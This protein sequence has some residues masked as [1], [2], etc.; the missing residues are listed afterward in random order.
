MNCEKTLKAHVA[1]CNIKDNTNF[2]SFTKL[3]QD[4]S[5]ANYPTAEGNCMVIGSTK[6]AIHPYS[7]ISN[8]TKDAIPSDKNVSGRTEE[9]IPQFERGSGDITD[10][11]PSYNSVSFNTTNTIPQYSSTDNERL[12]SNAETN[13]E[14]FGNAKQEIIIGQSLGERQRD[15]GS[16]RNMPKEQKISLLKAYLK[17]NQSKPAVRKL[18]RQIS[19]MAG[20]RHSMEQV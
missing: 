16:L 11:I 4:R 7:I 10:E 15:R 9:T 6:E 2:V 1:S 5:S 20:T 14:C 17:G 13:F 3:L 8:H 19:E 18:I 12:C